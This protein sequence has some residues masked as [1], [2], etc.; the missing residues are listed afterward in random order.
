MKYI[1][2]DDYRGPGIGLYSGNPRGV[3]VRAAVRLDESDAAEEEVVVLVPED[4][5]AV[6]SSFLSGLLSKSI[7]SLGEDRFRELYSFEGKSIEETLDMVIGYASKHH[8][9]I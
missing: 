9:A 3:A 7:R 4:V 8:A 1:D 2:L 5:F 6:T